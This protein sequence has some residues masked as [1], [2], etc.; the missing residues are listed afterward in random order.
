MGFP[1]M[2]RVSGRMLKFFKRRV[3]YSDFLEKKPALIAL[4]SRHPLFHG[5]IL[6]FS[7]RSGHANPAG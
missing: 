1:G 7:P 3:E 2:L 6:R 5:Q 4:K